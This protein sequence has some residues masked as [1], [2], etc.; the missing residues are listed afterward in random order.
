MISA[1]VSLTPRCLRS[2][3]ANTA[4]LPPSALVP[5]QV[6]GRSI[7]V[8]EIGGFLCS[9]EPFHAWVLLFPVVLE[10]SRGHA[11]SSGRKIFNEIRN[12]RVYRPVS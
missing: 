2:L 9:C 12:A 6:T 5:Y 3:E 1:V 4:P 8:L 7:F 10:R 11:S